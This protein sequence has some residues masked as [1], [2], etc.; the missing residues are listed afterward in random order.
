MSICCDVYMPTQFPRS[1]SSIYKVT[2]AINETSNYIHYQF[3]LVVMVVRPVVAVQVLVLAGL[4]MVH[5]LVATYHTTHV[6]LVYN[7]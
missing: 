1:H 7:N 2:R 5:L 4:A 6:Y 3:N